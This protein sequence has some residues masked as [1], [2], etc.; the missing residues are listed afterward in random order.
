LRV[1]EKGQVTIPQ[2][3]RVA[4]NIS[5]GDEVEFECQG[6]QAV[7]RRVAQPEQVAERIA[8]YRGS[9]DAG[10]STEEILEMTRE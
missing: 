7:L 4:L 6:E 3:V 5:P 10:L 8:A 1:T 9:A 2:S